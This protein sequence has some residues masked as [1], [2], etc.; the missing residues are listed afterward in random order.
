MWAKCKEQPVVPLGSLATAG[1]VILAARS[2][3][4]GEKLKTQKYFRYRIAFQLIT[5]IA[6][7]L[8]SVLWHKESI[9]YKAKHEQMLRDKA[10]KREQLWIEE[11]ERRDAELQAR[12][13]RAE[14]SRAELRRVAAEG[15]QQEARTRSKNDTSESSGSSSDI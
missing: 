10:K 11:L 5:L 8:G 9:D 6:L 13:K 4:R 7:V 2:M 12:K 3:K 1:A 15:F 14:E